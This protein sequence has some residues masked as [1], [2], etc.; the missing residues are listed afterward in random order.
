VRQP[1]LVEL[2]LNLAHGLEVLGVQLAD[3]LDRLRDAAVAA[4]PLGPGVPDRI[5][6]AQRV[7]QTDEVGLL[8]VVEDAAQPAVRR[9]EV[10]VALLHVEP[11]TEQMEV[12]RAPVELLVEL[13]VV[14]LALAPPCGDGRHPALD[15]QRPQ[16]SLYGRRALRTEQ[17]H[18]HRG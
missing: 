5:D 18:T 12:D 16:H 2:D 1:A 7:V 4:R 14:G 9:G 10:R 11:P 3:V 13:A 6:R 17:R 15:G 8:Y